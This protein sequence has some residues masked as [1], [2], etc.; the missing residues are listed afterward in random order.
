MNFKCLSNLAG[1]RIPNQIND[2]EITDLLTYS[3]NI[4]HN[5]KNSLFIAKRCSNYD[6]HQLIKAR[7][8][9]GICSFIIEKNIAFKLQLDTDIRLSL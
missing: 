1:G 3:R 8:N 2:P 5:G 9:K 6:R 4:S 7:Y